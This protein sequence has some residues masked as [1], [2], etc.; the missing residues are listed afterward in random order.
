[1]RRHVATASS[2]QVGLAT[3][4]IDSYLRRLGLCSARTS[5]TLGSGPGS[6]FREVGG[7]T[8]VDLGNGIGVMPKGGGAAATVAKARGGVAQV[9]SAGQE[10]A[11][12]VVPAAL[13]VEVHPGGLRG[14]GDLVCGP[15]R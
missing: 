4:D 12:G 3:F 5:A 7:S 10:L 6:E 1:M 11:G 14:L 8:P 2:H 9:E 15:V 13:D